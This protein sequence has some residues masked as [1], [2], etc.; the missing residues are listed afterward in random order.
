MYW[1]TRHTLISV[2]SEETT[3]NVLFGSALFDQQLV[4]HAFE[5][6]TLSIT[7]KASRHP[8]I[9]S[10]IKTRPCGISRYPNLN[11]LGKASK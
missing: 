9:P 4:L 6:I 8:D 2:R 11:T 10:D 5:F 7:N 1:R 3:D